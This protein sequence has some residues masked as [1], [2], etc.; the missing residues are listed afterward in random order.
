MKF[1]QIISE[2]S[3]EDIQ[4]QKKFASLICFNITIGIRS[5]NSY[6]DLTDKEKLNS[7]ILLNELQHR[8]INQKGAN[9]PTELINLKKLIKSIVNQNK[10]AAKELGAI[11]QL[12]FNSYKENN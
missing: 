4:F 3:K 8:I 1:D 6:T 9:Y 2:V 5:I 10:I 7:I 11:V 12:A